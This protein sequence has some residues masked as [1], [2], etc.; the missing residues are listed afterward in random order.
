MGTSLSKEGSLIRIVEYLKE[1]FLV[2]LV[3]ELRVYTLSHSTSL[4]FVCDEF[5]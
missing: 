4:F 1:I 5:F 2:V 3:F